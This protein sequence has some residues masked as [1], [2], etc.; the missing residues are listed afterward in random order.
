MA[1]HR[2]GNHCSAERGRGR[3]VCFR[4]APNSSLPFLFSFPLHVPVGTLQIDSAIWMCQGNVIVSFPY[5]L[6]D[7]LG[8]Q[9]KDMRKSRPVLP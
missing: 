7:R 5:N 8:K 9:H 1:E 2:H 4:C 6:S 3:E